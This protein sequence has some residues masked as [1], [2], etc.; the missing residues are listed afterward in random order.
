MYITNDYLRQKNK[1]YCSLEYR[2]L[3]YLGNSGQSGKVEFEL[4]LEGGKSENL[5]VEI[6]GHY[7]RRIALENYLENG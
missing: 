1:S 4:N 3:F 6:S 7:S 5:E 2:I